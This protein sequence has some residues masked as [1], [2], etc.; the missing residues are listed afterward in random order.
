MNRRELLQRSSA[1]F[2][3]AATVAITG[4][5]SSDNGGD[6]GDGGDSDDGSAGDG[7][8]TDGES[9]GGS[10]GDGSGMGATATPTET[11]TATST[12]AEASGDPSGEVAEVVSGL[13]VTDFSA[14]VSAD[15]FAVTVTVE[16]VGDMTTT[17]EYNVDVTTYDP[18]GDRLNQGFTTIQRSYT[19]EYAPG[20]SETFEVD[21]QLDCPGAV[22]RYEVAVN[23]AATPNGGAY[24]E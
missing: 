1:T 9:G 4:C 21:P 13:E 17:M 14:A 18:D 24:C 11:A 19:G 8:D 20:E 3:T 10:S 15:T 23:C 16:N 5:S 7:T 12:C 22:A 2:A 6:G